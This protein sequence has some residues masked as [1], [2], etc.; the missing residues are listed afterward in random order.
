MQLGRC[1]VENAMSFRAE[2]INA[3]PEGTATIARQAFANGSVVMN[4]RDELGTLYEDEHLRELFPSIQG[5][6]AWSAWRLALITVMQ[7]IEDLSDA[8]AAQAVRGRIEMNRCVNK[9]VFRR[10][11][12]RGLE[13]PMQS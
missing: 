8:Q 12:Q 13:E 10:R 9:N 1:K 4:L 11:Y 6:P 3:I 2:S 5:Q 7:Y